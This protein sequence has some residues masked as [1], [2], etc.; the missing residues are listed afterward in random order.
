VAQLPTKASTAWVSASMP[1]A[2][3]MA[4]GRPVIS[5][6]VQRRHLGHHA[7]ID[8]DQLALAFGVGDDGRHRH[9]EPVP[10]VVGTA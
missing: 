1:V 10:A 2:A 4:G 8:D 7:R 6:R 5:A 3:V 9:L